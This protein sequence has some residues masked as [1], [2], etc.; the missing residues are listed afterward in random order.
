MKKLLEMAEKRA[1]NWESM[2]TRKEA[3]KNPVYVATIAGQ[4]AECLFW[5]R[6][7]KMLIERHG[8]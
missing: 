1:R 4:R 5:A 8:R 3:M 7:F 2:T 6:E